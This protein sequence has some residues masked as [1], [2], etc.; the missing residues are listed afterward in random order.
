MGR[1]N[2][3]K[4]LIKN[5]PVLLLLA[6]FLSSILF[7]G[8]ALLNKNQG[9]KNQ[10][11]SGVVNGKKEFYKYKPSGIYDTAKHKLTLKASD[12][13]L[14]DSKMWVINVE[15]GKEQTIKSL[16]FP[17]TFSANSDPKQKQV[18]F[19]N[20]FWDN[21]EGDFLYDNYTWRRNSDLIVTLESYKKNILKGKFSGGLSKSGSKVQVND[22]IF[23]IKVT[24]K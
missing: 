3:L 7:S 23:S 21:N 9:S 6:A 19:A 18:V 16:K 24:E 5:L 22:G 15:L 4:Y 17:R 11:I 20:I 1:K 8:C 13:M 12:T 10:F 2:S 14:E